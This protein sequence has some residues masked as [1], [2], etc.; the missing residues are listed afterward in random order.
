[1]LRGAEIT[2][3]VDDIAFVVEKCCLRGVGCKEI[4]TA[5][6]MLNNF[7]NIMLNVY[8]AGFSRIFDKQLE[9]PDKSVS[10]AQMFVSGETVKLTNINTIPN[11]CLII[12]LNNIATTILN[13][14]H[15]KENLM[16]KFEQTYLDCI[17]HMEFSN[18]KKA[19]ESQMGIASLNNIEELSIKFKQLLENACEKLCK[20]FSKDITQNLIKDLSGLDFQITNKQLQEFESHDPFLPMYF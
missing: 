19:K 15:L 12:G 16:K 8:Y 13:L 11:C 14:R 3:S 18:L 6:A 4:S 9:N 17:F 1:M 20:L 2:Q 7:Q 10:I 5:C